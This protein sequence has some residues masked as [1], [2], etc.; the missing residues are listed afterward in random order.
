MSKQEE[1]DDRYRFSSPACL[2]HELE[3]E[4]LGT[5]GA[6]AS[7]TPRPDWPEVK[8]WR[9]RTRKALL[10]HRGSLDPR[11]RRRRGETVKERLVAEVDLGGYG[12]LGVYWPIRGEIDVLDIARRHIGAGGEV[13]VPVITQKN[14]PVEFW[15]WRPGAKMRRGV[16]DIPVPAVRDPVRPDAL[17]IPLVGFDAAGFRLGYGGGYYDRTLAALAPCPFRVGLGYVESEL[18]TIYPQPHDVPMSLII[19]DE[20][21]YRAAPQPG[22]LHASNAQ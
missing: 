14:A 17:L 2:M 13:A 7:T 22:A 12:V 15:R 18:P 6:G 5:K 8:E 19:T 1:E 4:L 9:R 10:A 11:V 16:W 21:S 20:R 3:G